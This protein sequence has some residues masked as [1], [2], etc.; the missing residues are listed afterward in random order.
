MAHDLDMEVIAEGVETQGQ[1]QILSRMGCQYA[2]G[3]YI[4]KPLTFEETER[5]LTNPPK[6]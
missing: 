4:S 3:Y 6:L 5:F 2:Q 1:Y